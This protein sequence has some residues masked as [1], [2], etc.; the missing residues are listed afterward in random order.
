MTAHEL[1]EHLF[2]VANQLNRD[3][4]LLVNQDEKVQATTINL[5]AA[6]TARALA[7]Y[8]SACVYLAAGMALPALSRG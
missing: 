1:V 6:R 5:R 8:A 4:A 7:A 2:D 3:A